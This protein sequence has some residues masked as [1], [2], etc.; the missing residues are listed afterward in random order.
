MTCDGSSCPACESFLL[1][2]YTRFLQ[3]IFLSFCQKDESF[4]TQPSNATRFPGNQHKEITT[5][6]K[7]GTPTLTP[8]RPF[9]A[10]E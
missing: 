4:S 5:G 3:R 8:V 6:K 7:K 10:L 1:F 9:N 2:R